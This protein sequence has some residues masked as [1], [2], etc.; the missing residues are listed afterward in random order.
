M[1][2][3]VERLAKS[4]QKELSKILLTEIKIEHLNTV[5]VTEVRITNDLS[6]ATIYYICPEFLKD[7]VK[8]NLEHSKGFL[9]RELAHRIS[10]RKS[11]ELI[12]KYDEA[13]EYGNHINKLLNEI[14]E[15]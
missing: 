3:F 7:K 2:L 1:S 8:D 10:S 14:K 15:K 13:L 5:T 9:R 11:P 4:Y 12:F 6:F